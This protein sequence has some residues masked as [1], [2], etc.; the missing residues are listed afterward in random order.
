M[1]AK[2]AKNSWYEW[3]VS[4]VPEPVR[5]ETSRIKR[6]ILRLYNNTEPREFAISSSESA[7]RNFTERHTIQGVSEMDA[8]SFLR[9][10]RDT[11]VR[12]LRE[13]DNIKLYLRL[14]CV[15][16]RP[17]PSGKGTVAKEAHFSDKTTTKLLDDDVGE[18]YDNAS[19]KILENM[20]KY[21]KEGSGWRLKRVLRLDI[22]MT[23]FNPVG[24]S[25]PV[26]PSRWSPLTVALGNLRE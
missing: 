2:A 12:K 17:D 26:V 3:L 25:S 6:Q 9:R 13:K 5:S 21:R 10:V 20:A 22:H 4:H 14:V 23:E 7:L 8:T 11:V 18:M 1:K 19:E 24:G 16:E 15:I